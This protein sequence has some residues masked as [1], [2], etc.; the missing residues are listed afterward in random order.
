[1]RPQARSP[2]SRDLAN[3]DESDTLIAAFAHERKYVKLLI[4][5][6]ISD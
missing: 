3:H 4:N 1:M 2:S 5:L 6:K